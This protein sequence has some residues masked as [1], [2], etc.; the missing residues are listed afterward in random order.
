MRIL[1]MN[2]GVIGLLLFVDYLLLVWILG[3]EEQVS[4]WFGKL[5]TLGGS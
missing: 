5:L 3:G 2:I 4:D 1:I